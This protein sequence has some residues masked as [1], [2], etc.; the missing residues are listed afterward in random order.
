MSSLK[1]LSGRYSP[2]VWLLTVG[3]LV[4]MTTLWMA[5]PFLSIFINRA[6]A[7]VTTTG[8]VIAL[9]PAAQLVGNLMGGHWSDRRLAEGIAA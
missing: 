2:T 7:S 4:D 9:N 6:G 3:R 5:I 8:L 1:R